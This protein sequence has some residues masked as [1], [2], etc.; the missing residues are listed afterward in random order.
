MDNV[1]TVES[2]RK[3]RGMTSHVENIRAAP[4]FAIDREA[5]R[6]QRVVFPTDATEAARA[7]KMLRTQLL[8]RVRQQ[9]YRV[10]GITSPADGDGKTL[11]AVNLALSLAAEPN[12]TVLLADLDLHRPAMARVLGIEQHDGVDACLTRKLDVAAVLRRPV[13]VDRMSVLAANPVG[14][15]SSEL[16][17]S[18]ATRTL[19]QEIRNRYSD[20]LILVDLP[21][22]LLTDDVL[23]LTPL[24]D[25]VLLVVSERRTRREDVQRTVDLLSGVPILGT[26]LNHAHEV[27]RRVY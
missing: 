11:T 16:L 10:I 7:Y 20:R 24:L 12:Q 3:E 13:G 25:A 6:R 14:S 17:A 26:V 9:R 5:L 8:M 15:G 23:A 1:V 18:D 19:V 21:P 27:E 2:A 22:V 4:R